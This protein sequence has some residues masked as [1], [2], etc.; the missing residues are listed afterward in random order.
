M[1]SE[2]D[3]PKLPPEVWRRVKWPISLVSG[4]LL[5]IGIF[6][7]LLLIAWP[8]LGPTLIRLSVQP[9]VPAG[10]TVEIGDIDT[11]WGATRFYDV[12][13]TT[14][15]PWRLES[16][17]VFVRHPVSFRR[18]DL[19]DLGIL[20]EFGSLVQEASDQSTSAIAAPRS[21]PAAP[22]SLPAPPG[23]T[24]APVNSSP[25]VVPASVSASFAASR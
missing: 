25:P 14:D 23:S 18:Q 10:W 17:E 12:T 11:D 2:W 9:W 15:G 16:V 4:L 22:G 20:I 21:L 1:S 5:I 3:L 8:W 13:V 19:D 6:F 24:S 7:G